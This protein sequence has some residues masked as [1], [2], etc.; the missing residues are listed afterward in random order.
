MTIKHLVISGGGHSI[1]RTI[2]ALNWLEQREYWR[3]CDIESIYG[4]SAGAIFGAI[5]CLQFE[6]SIV[7]NYLLNRPWHEA[8]TIK[9]DQL[10]SAYANK[11]V[12]DHTAMEIIF[13]PLL[14]AKDLPLSLTMK[15]LYE[16][17]NIELHM[18][19]LEVNAFK[20]V[21]ISHKTHPDLPLL[22]A[23]VMTSAIPGIFS[24]FCDDNGHCFVDGG[25]TSNYPLHWCVNAGHDLDEIL[26]LKFNY[27]KEKEENKVHNSIITKDSNLLDF[28][29]TLFGKLV[30]KVGTENTQPFVP[31]E[32]V[33]NATCMSYE[34]LTS[35]LSSVENR[36]LLLEE[37][38]ASAK[39]FF[40]SRKLRVACLES[41]A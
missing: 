20:T 21:D 26:G 38:I 7:E 16:F 17:S 2:G 22:S 18:F 15:E 1:F 36:K 41:P 14:S 23:L 9:V 3:V 35:A 33:C 11:G 5:I 40:E 4:T 27:D 8:F 25:V 28:F 12:F 29:L 19:S 24:P 39:E 34:T 10:I 32:V 13:K 6:H 37:G 31:N 30:R